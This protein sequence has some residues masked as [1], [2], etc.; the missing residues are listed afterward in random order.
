MPLLRKM[1]RRRVRAVIARGSGRE[2]SPG[3]LKEDG[4]CCAIST[5]MLGEGRIHSSSRI[6]FAFV[7]R[8]EMNHLSPA[9]R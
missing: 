3:F 8:N 2:T 9:F 5:E 7:R 6:R 4:D 1:P